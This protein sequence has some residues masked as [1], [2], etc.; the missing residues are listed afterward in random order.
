MSKHQIRVT[1]VPDNR[2]HFVKALRLVGGMG[3]QQANDLAIHLDRFRNSVLVAGIDGSV[4][5][6]ISTLLQASGVAV[7]VEDCSIGTPMLCSPAA[8]TQY[9]W[10][11]FR[12]IKKVS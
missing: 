7:A 3:L 9:E 11:K 12:L 2:V 4:A 10:G 1:G 5:E 8:N 6:H